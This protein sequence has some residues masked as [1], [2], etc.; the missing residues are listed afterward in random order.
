MAPDAAQCPLLD[1]FVDRGIDLNA[2][3]GDIVHALFLQNGP[4]VIR[5]KLFSNIVENDIESVGHFAFFERDLPFTALF[6]LLFR[7][8]VH[9]E[10]ISENI[11]FSY[12]GQRFRLFSFGVGFL[13]KGV[14]SVRAFDR[15]G[16]K[17]ALHKV[18]ICG[19][20]VKEV[21]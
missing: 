7:N 3:G 6:I 20:L 2:G 17:G 18:K 9:L 21:L 11:V 13:G 16:Y 14:V 8:V 19:L 1:F 5:F 12:F 10:H 15:T 4:E